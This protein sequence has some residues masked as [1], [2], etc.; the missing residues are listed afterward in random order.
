MASIA[1]RLGVRYLS[2]PL[3]HD[4]LFTIVTLVADQDRYD[5]MLESAAAKGFDTSNSE[6]IALDNRGANRFDGFDAMRR[7]L[8]E[9]KGRWIVFTHDDV[10]FDADGVDAL[11]AR[12][13]ELT[14]LDPGWTL[15]GNA[16]GIRYRRGNPLLALHIADPHDKGERQAAPVLVESLDEN[17]FV[18]RRDRPVLNSYDL[19]GFH[20]YAGDLCRISEVM[21][22]RAYV[23]PFLLRH[24]SGGKIDASFAPARERFRRKYR[25]YFIGRDL[26]T[27]VTEFRF[28]LSG[29]REGWG[30]TAASRH[31]Y[32][33]QNLAVPGLAGTE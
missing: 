24:H 23:I 16:G 11:R 29:L 30:E 31:S 27:T 1:D 8:P 32:Q 13:E 26:Q 21:G 19:S 9:A 7:T 3:G 14:A 28:G 18:M 33:Q 4:V 25:R 5:R 2:G 10:E 15:A 20:F 12:L 17:F 22:G 6:F